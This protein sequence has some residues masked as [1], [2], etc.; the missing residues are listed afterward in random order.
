MKNAFSEGAKTLK[1]FKSITVDIPQDLYD[2]VK[3]L[4]ININRVVNIALQRSVKILGSE[5]K[6]EE[7][8]REM[9]EINLGLAKMCLE[10]DN[11]ALKVTE[12]YLT[13]CE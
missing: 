1:S 3:K 13:E 12:Q 7:G 10:A 6:L 5:K 2:E 4:N 8:Y 11:D 9:S